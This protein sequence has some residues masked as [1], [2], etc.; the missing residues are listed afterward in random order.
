MITKDYAKAIIDLVQYFEQNGNTLDRSLIKGIR[1]LKKDLEKRTFPKDPI[2]YYRKFFT[3]NEFSN[4]EFEWEI[5]NF[6]SDLAKHELG[7]AIV[8]NYGLYLHVQPVNGKIITHFC[9]PHPNPFSFGD[10]EGTV[11]VMTLIHS[12]EAITHYAVNRALSFLQEDNKVFI[13]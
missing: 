5:K 7:K 1:V 12:H 9:S 10:Y 11:K 8:M 2:M 3:D 4:Q 13:E 6:K